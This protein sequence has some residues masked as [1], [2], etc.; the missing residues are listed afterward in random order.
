MVIVILM[1]V[2]TVNGEAGYSSDVHYLG[3]NC[4]ISCSE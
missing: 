2:I 4:N 1:I 3:C